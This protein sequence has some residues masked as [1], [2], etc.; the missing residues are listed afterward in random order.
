MTPNIPLLAWSPDTDP[1]VPGVIV[2]MTN[3]LP[4][5]RGY[6][7][8]RALSDSV[9]GT[10]ALAGT[11][12]GAA[13]LRFSTNTPC[14]V[15]ATSTNLYSFFG[16]AP[17]LVSRSASPYTAVSGPYQA[18]HFASFEN[19]ALAISTE[20]VL[21]ASAGPAAGSLFAD[22]PDA[23]AAATICVQSNFVLLANMTTGAWPYGDGVWCSG[24]ETYTDWDA[25][26]ATQGKQMRLLQTPGPIVR[27][28]A[29]GNYVIAFKEGSMLRGT[30]IGLPSV[31]R[32]DVISTSV[33]IV[34]HDAVC[35]ANGVLY[36]LSHDGFYRFAGGAPE[37][38]NSAPFEWFCDSLVTPSAL[39]Y[40]VQGQWDSARRLVRWYYP[41]VGGDVGFS[42]GIAYHPSTDRWGPF[43]CEVEWSLTTYT[44]S[45]ARGTASAGASMYYP[46]AVFDADHTLSVFGGSALDS[47]LT[48]GDVG[49]DD[50]V[51][52]TMRARARFLS[53]PTTSALT[54]SH[55][56]V[57][58]D[59]LT[60]GATISRD[61]GKYD[62]T[63]G[64]RWHR[65]TLAQTGYHE[66]LGFSVDAK[67]AGKR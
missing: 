33:G 62:I 8:D 15:A 66:L 21:Q 14:V 32:W 36:W 9:W 30:Y 67:P 43:T 55:R 6:T 48:T 51:L 18:W 12:N 65:F 26:L 45:A 23:P 29:F 53:A 27:L 35:D 64:A 17:I 5:Q 58:S 2:E 38:I 10:S 46:A 19:T 34:G 24:I 39:S 7:P 25:D 56:M 52:A 61:D 60:T 41:E 54:H 3:L 28:Y 59:S 42:R 16:G 31:W 47:S 44:D 50:A 57:L 40:Y 13:L 20:N 49:D 63:H 37:R 11:C 1:T 4:T 22:V